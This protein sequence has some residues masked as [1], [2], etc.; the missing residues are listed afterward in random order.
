[1]RTPCC[2]AIALCALAAG[3]CASSVAPI[4]TASDSVEEPGLVG[5]WSSEKPNELDKIRIEKDKGSK[6]KVTIHDQKSGND[7]VYETH[8]LK[9]QNANFADLLISDYRH[10]EDQID[11]PFGAE[12]LH[13]IV[14]YQL[15]GD[16][17]TI[18]AIDGDA[19]DKASKKPGFSIQFGRNKRD[20][21]GGDP[22]I[23]SPT[24]V[25]RAYLSAHPSDIFGEPARL[26]RQH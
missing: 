20:G 10:G 1:M 7:S 8:L 18:W 23:V 5:N 15:K 3:G 26:K 12:P 25:I 24:E 2:I 4:Y 14:K 17:L 9:L 19:F 22:I 11:L 6:Y 13:Q 16:D 21:D